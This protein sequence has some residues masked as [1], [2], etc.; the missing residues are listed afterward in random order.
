M[1]PRNTSF[2]LLFAAG[3]SL[4]AR[5]V[6][7]CVDLDS[8][9]NGVRSDAGPD[10]GS[11]V[12]ETSTPDPCE[13]V[14]PAERPAVSAGDSGADLKTFVI[15]IRDIALD[16][17][18]APGLDLD[19]I[20]TCDKRPGTNQGGKGS[21]IAVNKDHCDGDGGIDNQLAA[22]ASIV[23]ATSPDSSHIDQVAARL[24]DQGRKTLLFEVAGYNGKANDDEVVVSVYLA[25][26]LPEKGCPSSEPGP[27]GF[28]I[29]GW[30]GNDSWH[31][32]NSSVLSGTS[33]PSLFGKGWVTNYQLVVP[34]ENKVVLPFGEASNA[35]IDRATLEGKLVPLDEGMQERDPTIPPTPAQERLWRLKGTL[36]GR[37]STSDILATLGAYEI[38]GA[39]PLCKG[40][41]FPS[42]AQLV[43]SYAD[44]SMTGDNLTAPCDALSAAIGLTADPVLKG[45]VNPEP[46]G[47]Q[48]GNECSPGAP[49]APEYKC[50]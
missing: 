33:V 7:A 14:K 2:L 10:D 44:L 3:L 15:A 24:I 18:K 29:P 25:E 34:F 45:P 1:R 5:G 11:I 46:D 17:E 8:L 38:G 26:G 13:R 19:N 42:I 23:Q 48:M 32:S 49:G 16:L 20:C 27:V 41:N 22:L 30:C 6:G 36:V 35:V 12:P 47:G 39:G 4:L 21:C 40:S 31:V 50:K 43:C 37:S 28:F 9:G